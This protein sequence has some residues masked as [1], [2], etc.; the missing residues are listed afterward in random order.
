MAKGN[1]LVG[2]QHPPDTRQPIDVSPEAPISG[3]TRKTELDGCRILVVGINYWPEPLGIAP[4]TTG[5]AEH[6]AVLG[7]QVKVV[8]GLPHYPSWTVPAEF[9]KIRTIQEHNGVEIHRLAHSVPRAMTGLRRASYEATFALHA[10]VATLRERPDLV[11]AVSPALGGAGVGARLARR[12]R[13]PLIVVVQD[14]MAQAASQSGISG[15]SSLA[16]LATKLERFALRSASVVAPVSDAF[17]PAL[18]RLGV[19]EDHISLLRNWTHANGPRLS[20]DEARKALGWSPKEFLAIHTGSMGLKQDLGNVIEAAR[21]IGPETAIRFVIVGDGS[22][23]ASLEAQACDVANLDLMDP[24]SDAD[25]LHVLAAA[26]V[27]IVNERP[28]VGDM[29]LPSKLTSYLAA[30][31]PVVA[32]VSS[33]GSTALELQRTGGAAITVA[34]AEPSALAAAIRQ[35]SADA[36]AC[37]IM[38]EAAATYASEHLVA[39]GALSR[40]ETLAIRALELR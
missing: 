28:T 21:L 14:L 29:S 18:D 4:Y 35:L 25:Y 10:F 37:R 31:R 32:A 15:G 24:V 16:R 12:R 20:R 36:S 22:Q 33:S 17:R 3:T 9:K 40:V 7:A 34:P 27:L 6:L 5:M 39:G 19:D 30:G 38:S 26:D 13:V 1:S 23:R 2:R 11:I 8:T